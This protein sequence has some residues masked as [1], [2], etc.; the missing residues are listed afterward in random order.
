MEV[1]KKSGIP[2]KSSKSMVLGIPFK[3]TPVY[4]IIFRHIPLT[5]HQYTIPWS[6]DSSWIFIFHEYAVSFISHHIPLYSIIFHSY[7]LHS[8]PIIPLYSHPIIPLY[9]HPIIISHHIPWSIPCPWKQLLIAAGHMASHEGEEGM[10]K[11]LAMPATRK[12]GWLLHSIH[13]Y[14][15]RFVLWF[16]A[17]DY[18]NCLVAFNGIDEDLR[19][20]R[21]SFQG[22]FG[23]FLALQTSL[24]H[25]D[26]IRQH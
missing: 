16:L 8:H 2:L 14:R 5:S 19:G 12:G 26:L 21:S 17:I 23:R 13:L 10:V 20:F 25:G 22:T 15:S 18:D 6:M 24:K 4:P 3:E 11:D 1:S 7:P 9:S